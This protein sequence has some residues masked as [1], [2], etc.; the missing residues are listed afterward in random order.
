MIADTPRTALSWVV[1]SRG[2]AGIV[3]DAASVRIGRTMRRLPHPVANVNSASAPNRTVRTTSV[4]VRRD[5][6]RGVLLHPQH[7]ETKFLAACAQESLHKR[8]WLGSRFPRAEGGCRYYNHAREARTSDGHRHT[9]PCSTFLQAELADL[10]DR[11][12]RVLGRARHSTTRP[13]RVGDAVNFENRGWAVCQHVTPV[14]RWMP[15]ASTGLTLNARRT[16]VVSSPGAS[17]SGAPAATP[18]G[19]S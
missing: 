1:S 8:A 11:T 12:L 18:A 15:K 19:R 5:G 17:K 16:I 2:L 9:L 10:R 14:G 3:S 4:A 13:A 7:C 6:L